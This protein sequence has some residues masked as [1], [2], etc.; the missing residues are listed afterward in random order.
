MKVAAVEEARVWSTWFL[1]GIGR[2]ALMV[3]PEPTASRV[4]LGDPSTQAELQAEG[5]E[6]MEVTPPKEWKRRTPSPAEKGASEPGQFPILQ[7]L[8]GVP[9]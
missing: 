8:G 6:A 3:Q 9:S 1:W 4:A 2:E 7:V 5:R